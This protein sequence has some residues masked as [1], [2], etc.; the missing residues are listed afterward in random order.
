[1]AIDYVEYLETVLK[2]MWA[3]Y[4]VDDLDNC[5]HPPPRLYA[6]HALNPQTGKA[7]IL[8]VACCEC[9]AVLQGAADEVATS[10]EP[11]FQKERKKKAAAN[12]G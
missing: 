3:Q 11:V 10:P 6:W 2:P 7:D 1:M 4:K 8:C 5:P 9:G 12:Q